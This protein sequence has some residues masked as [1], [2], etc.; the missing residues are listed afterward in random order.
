MGEQPRL[1]PAQA[2][3]VE[4]TEGLL[5]IAG[6]GS[7]KTH[8]LVERTVRL[9][10]E[11]GVLPDQILLCTFTEKAAA[12]LVTRITL[13]LAEIGHAADLAEMFIG[14]LHSICLRILDEFRE[15]TRLKRNFVIWD[16]FDQQYALYRDLNTFQE[17]DGAPAVLG[18]AGAGSRWR[19]AE[20]LAA[21]LNQVSEEL[22]DVVEL[23]AS[24]DLRIR[25]LARLHNQYSAFLAER[26]AL[27]FSLIQ[28]EACRLLELDAEVLAGLRSRLRYAMVD[29]YQDTNTVQERLL[30]LLAGEAG[31]LCVVGDDDQAL[32]RFRG[33]TV[34]NILEFPDSFSPCSREHLTVNYRSQP[35]IVDFYSSWMSGPRLDGR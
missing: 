17:V 33:A 34:R 29:E 9:I 7:G 26:N 15:R 19:Q 32:Y 28:V 25:A 4:Q 8:T 35:G 21:R 20:V 23:E 12:E 30:R 10:T 16:K 6:P 14:T 13:R 1:D 2:R 22:L 31:N 24:P 11:R 18:P 27:D 3:A 5:I